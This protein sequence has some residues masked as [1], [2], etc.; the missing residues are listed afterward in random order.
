[1]K[2]ISAE[3]GGVK[4]SV[5]L[6]F[7]LLSALLHIGIKVVPLFLAEDDLKDK[8]AEQAAL[9]HMIKDEAITDNL[10]SKAREDGIPLRPQDIRL[11]RND[12]ARSMQISAQWDV[13]VRFFFDFYPPYTTQIIKFAPVVKEHYAIKL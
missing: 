6:I 3:R 9:A 5:L 11:L 2:K 1:M 12:D 13:T 7:V 10:M 4:I 8:M